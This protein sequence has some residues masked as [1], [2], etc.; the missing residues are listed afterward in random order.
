MLVVSRPA[1]S[2]CTAA[3]FFWSVVPS[4]MQRC[5]CRVACGDL[6]DDCMPGLGVQNMH[7][8]DRGRHLL[9]MYG[10]GLLAARYLLITNNT[11]HFVSRWCG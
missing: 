11:F 2:K 7:D 10:V 4:R 6:C 8:A 9:D 5:T 1:G 3:Q